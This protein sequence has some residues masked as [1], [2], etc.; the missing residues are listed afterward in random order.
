M[1]FFAETR[2]AISAICIDLW[3]GSGPAP[4]P[5]NA[6]K[7]FQKC[8][9]FK[10]FLSI[11]LSRFQY[12]HLNVNFFV[13][14]QTTCCTRFASYYLSGLSLQ[15]LCSR[16]LYFPRLNAVK[17]WADNDSRNLCSSVLE[18]Y[19]RRR[20]ALFADTSDKLFYWWL[21]NHVATGMH[22]FA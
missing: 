6:L 5:K 15:K 18:R 16:P 13:R 4:K 3:E 8:P 17:R 20:W 10:N 22:R 1:G 9:N 11:R 21:H 14:Y 12:L 2:I 19:V 7:W